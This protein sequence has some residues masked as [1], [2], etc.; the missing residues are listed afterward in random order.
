MK[1][2]VMGGMGANGEGGCAEE[3]RRKVADG[4]N[5][6]ERPQSAMLHAAG[7]EDATQWWYYAEHWSNGVPEGSQRL[8]GLG[9][10]AE[11]DA[12]R[13]VSRRNFRTTMRNR[14]CGS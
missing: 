13:D 9:E 14:S 10:A 11:R 6:W 12:A 1:G 8:E 3:R 7:R 5:A 2:N 4:S